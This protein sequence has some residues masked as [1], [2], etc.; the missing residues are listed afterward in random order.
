MGKEAAPW[1]GLFRV[2]EPRRDGVSAIR[3][4]VTNLSHKVRMAQ[5]GTKHGH[6]TGVLEVMLA[7]P[8][9]DVVGVY[10]PDPARRRMLE[11][12]GE[13]PWSDV[14]WFDSPAEFLDDPSVL[15]IASEGSNAESLDHTE[16]I[17]DAG[18]HVFYDKP[19]GT[20]YV[21]FERI[22]EKARSSGLQVQMGYMFRH[23]AGF[24]RIA[25]WARSGL[26]GDIFSIRAHMSTHLY[27]PAQE[28]IAPHR[29]GIFYD[30]SGHMIDQIAWILGRP[31]KVTSF[32]RHD[33][34]D[35]AGFSDNTLCV[36]EY[37]S[38]MAFIDIAAVETPPMARRFEVYGTVGS[39]IM[40][41][42][43]PPGPIRL[44]LSE[45]RGG[46]PAGVSTVEVEDRPRYVDNLALF[47]RALR[48]ENAPDRSLDHELLVQE[49][50][51]RCTG[52]ISD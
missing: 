15:A 17:V 13:P 38:A 50:I 22:V 44:C 7:N 6:A 40:E 18:K 52:H 9:V 30:L 51:L 20:D 11:G 16:A 12:A 42:F 46:Y 48:G 24:S 35:V 34:T 31:T 47:V 23:H 1:S 43:E 5:Y 29:G 2:Q 26:L 4:G 37:D 39:A 21:L 33:A 25:D 32:L 36:L 3:E 19:A 45:E 14:S 10:E 27:P 28:A 41:P 8:E 49:T